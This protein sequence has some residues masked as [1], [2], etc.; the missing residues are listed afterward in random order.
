M[1][2]FYHNLLSSFALSCTVHPLHRSNVLP[3]LYF[4]LGYFGWTNLAFMGLFTILVWNGHHLHGS[5]E[6]HTPP[7]L[8]MRKYLKRLMFLY[9]ERKSFFFRLTIRNRKRNQHNDH[10]N[11]VIK[12]I[13][14]F[15]VFT[16]KSLSTVKCKY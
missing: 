13:L 16:R 11:N 9:P 6:Q 5:T 8:Q 14:D 2:Q 3:V 7:K 10:D 12:F 15:K 4:S 1:K